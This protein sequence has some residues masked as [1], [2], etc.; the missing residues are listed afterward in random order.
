MDVYLISGAGDGASL[1]NQDSHGVNSTIPRKRQ[2]KT[3][4]HREREESVS[5]L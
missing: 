2:T 3:H 1:Q 4:T 5:S